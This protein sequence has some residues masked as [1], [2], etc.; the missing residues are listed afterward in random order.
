[1]GRLPRV[2]VEGVLYYVTS[3][4]GHGQNIFPHPEDYND[5]LSLVANYK[6]QYGF[7]LF[8]YVLLA[9]HLHMLIELKNSIGI[10]SIMHDVN[11]RYT[12]NYN[13]RYGKKG[14]LF[15]ERFRTVLAEKD[16]Y[17][18]QIIRCIH[19]NPVRASLAKDPKDY[20][21]SSHARYLDPSKR[22]HPDMAGE[23][24]EVFALLKGREEE[25]DKYVKSESFENINE[26]RNKLE[27]GVILGPK[28][29]S[30]RIKKMIRESVE[31]DE[32][33]KTSRRA[34]LV[35]IVISGVVILVSAI[36]VS[37]F[38]RQEKVIRTKY[39]ETLVVY[40]KT[41]EMLN[42]EKDIALKTNQDVE[43]YSWKIRA[44]EK[45]LA[46]VK[47]E[48]RRKAEEAARTEKA[49]N[50]YTWKIEL[51]AGS[52]TTTASSFGSDTI[53]FE[54]NR[55]NSTALNQE[56]FQGSGYTRTES[57]KGTVIWETFQTS[58][59]GETASW[60]GEWDGKVMKGILSRRSGNDVRDFSFVSVGERT[61]K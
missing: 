46:D 8:S 3:K 18:L 16:P 38:Y 25:F 56:G 11:S 12:K 57:G 23:I 59:T 50:G 41:L 44:A 2:Y 21:Y 60:R 15:Q 24:E 58:K 20:P 54:N 26:F 52:A 43:E 48:N 39:D 22:A 40:E 31:Q 33:P 28:D 35:Y 19:L 27:R 17:L 36:A 1:M 34:N 6:K 29:F 14:H 5:Y 53:F 30:D 32:A 55:M 49:L 45:A 13:G 42:R 61:K 10:S 9:D 4:G 7:K 47:E 37:Y 51:K